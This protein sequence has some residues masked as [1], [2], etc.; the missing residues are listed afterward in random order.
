M[1]RLASNSLGTLSSLALFGCQSIIGADF[2]SVQAAKVCVP[3]H[4]PTRPADLPMATDTVDF[5]V[6]LDELA[7]GDDGPDA[8]A[9]RSVGYDQDGVCTV[10]GGPPSCK[11]Y[12]WLDAKPL[13]DGDDGRDDAVGGLFAA[14]KAVFGG[15]LIGSDEENAGVMAGTSAPPGVLRVRGFSGLATDDHVVVELFQAAALDFGDSAELADGGMRRP[16]LDATDHWPIVRAT[17]TED[18][19]GTDVAS[20]QRDDDAFVVDSTLVAHF[21]HLLLPMH[22][23]YVE[24][25]KA[26]LS[27]HLAYDASTG[28]VLRDGTLAARIL[29]DFLLGFVPLATRSTVNVSLC[30]D[31]V[32]N[33]Q[34]VK[35]VLCGAADLPAKDDDPDSSCE[36]TS[37][38]LGF[39]SSPAS[40]GPVVDIVPPPSPCS[41]DTDPG[42]DTC[43]TR[44]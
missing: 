7:F 20:S 2:G 30:T 34:V 25:S 27:G 35:K 3:L 40:L 6:V 11:A 31:D 22:N 44:E 29:T 38:G 9:S 10:P 24:V 28:W 43:A 17:L 1:R 41:P 33:Y 23:I 15:A 36:F 18:D 13:L 14:Q 12:P 16:A 26:V 42:R 37:L 39:Q 8:G 4:A 19:A 32:A 5:T 21:D